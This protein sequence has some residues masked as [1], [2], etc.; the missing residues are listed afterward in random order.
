MNKKKVIEKVIDIENYY[1]AEFS[2]YEKLK[3]GTRYTDND[4]PDM[5]FHNFFRMQ[6]V[7]VDKIM[8][9]ELDEAKFREKN[10]QDF[11]QIEIFNI[12]KSKI[13]KYLDSE[14][15]TEHEIMILKI[16][17]FVEKKTNQNAIV[18]IAKTKSDFEKGME[19]DCLSFGENMREFAKSRY[20]RKMKKYKEINT[21][22]NNFICYKG[23][24]LIGNC[25]FYIKD[26][27][28]K[29][30]DF[31]VL[32]KYQKQG[33]GSKILTSIKNYGRENGVKY[34]FLQV[35]KENSAKEMY[36]K[37]GFKRLF[38]NIIYFKKNGSTHKTYQSFAAELPVS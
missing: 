3:Y 13:E 22:I 35:D 7:S 9:A 1:S 38:N 6:N 26:N 32:E 36:T 33:F 14:K 24:E 23:D 8:Q 37:I 12:K 17:D 19:I 10:K 30:E 27:Y 18:K 4:L 5:Y 15:L 20:L 31:D 2:I 16:E 29:I 25:D 34:L 21:N 28:G 11:V